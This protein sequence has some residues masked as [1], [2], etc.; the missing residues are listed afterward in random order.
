MKCATSFLRMGILDAIIAYLVFL[1]RRTGA[2]KTVIRVPAETS[3]P[4]PKPLFIPAPG[5]R[6]GYSASVSLGENPPTPLFVVFR[7]VAR[8]NEIEILCGDPTATFP[9]MDVEFCWHWQAT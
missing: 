6:Q 8:D 1:S 7:I 5:C 2:G 4:P 9:A 3:F